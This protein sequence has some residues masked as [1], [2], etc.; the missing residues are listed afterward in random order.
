MRT[1]SMI[2]LLLICFTIPASAHD[3]RG[4]RGH[5]GHGRGEWRGALLEK[6]EDM[7]YPL[8][9]CTYKIVGTDYSLPVIKKGLCPFRIEVNLETGAVRYPY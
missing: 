8:R 3:R 4:G 1:L 9:Q 2:M 7:P 6:E 5:G